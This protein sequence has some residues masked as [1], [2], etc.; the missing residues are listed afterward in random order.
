MNKIIDNFFHMGEKHSRSGEPC[1]DYSISGIIN[2]NISYG[3]ISD[4]CSGAL[5]RTDIG[6][7][8]WCIAAEK[9]IKT[10]NRN[11]SLLPADFYLKVRD[12]FLKNRLTDKHQDE[13]ASLVLFYENNDIIN[14]WMMGD[15]GYAIKN[16]NDEIT[17]YFYEWENNKPFYPAYLLDNNDIFKLFSKRDSE[18]NLITETKI[19]YVI[20][21]DRL[22]ILERQKTNIH[23]SEFSNGYLKIINRKEQNIKT[24]A[25]MTDGFWTLENTNPLLTIANIVNLKD[26]IFEGNKTFKR[27]MVKT[28][29]NWI[30]TQTIPFDDIGVAII[31]YK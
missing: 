1:E 26:N 19:R 2:E 10:L 15:G 24:I 11:D 5:S 18:N 6:A 21:N 13:Y 31:S 20:K 3:I 29:D 22:N 14:L 30:D 25:V 7:R 12:V 16:I 23:F 27:K 17:L 8:A 4:G 28:L 9:V